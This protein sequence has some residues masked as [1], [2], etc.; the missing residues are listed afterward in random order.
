MQSLVCQTNLLYYMPLC[1]V[2]TRIILQSV[3]DLI[4]P[5]LMETTVLMKITRPG[6]VVWKVTQ[7]FYFKAMENYSFPKR[8]FLVVMEIHV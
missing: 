7:R 5:R 1:A 4:T 3:L 8:Q 6:F 2:V